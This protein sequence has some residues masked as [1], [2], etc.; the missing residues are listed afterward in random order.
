MAFDVRP[1]FRLRRSQRSF[2]Y[3]IITLSAIFALIYN[4]TKS[5]RPNHTFDVF[6]PVNGIFQIRRLSG[7][8]PGNR[9]TYRFE[10]L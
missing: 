10:L 9:I 5:P 8:S 3:G 2:V 4:F 7:Q 6:D 1:H